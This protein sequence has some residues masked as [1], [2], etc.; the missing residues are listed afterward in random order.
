MHCC[1]IGV[2]MTLSERVPG[3]P[4]RKLQIAEIDAKPGADAGP[5]RDE[6]DPVVLQH[7]EADAGHDIGGT[8]DAAEPVVEIVYVVEVVDE[9]H[10]ARSL[11][12][13]VPAERRAL[14]EHL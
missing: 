8:G 14:P 6:Q 1:R 9:H 3:R 12:A 7:V 13:E 5:D 4:L 2:A 10:D 11:A